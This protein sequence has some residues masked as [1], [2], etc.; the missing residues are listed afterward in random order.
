MMALLIVSSSPHVNKA[1]RKN[2]T[3]GAD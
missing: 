1:S 2:E 3:C